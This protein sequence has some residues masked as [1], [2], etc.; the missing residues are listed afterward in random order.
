MTPSLSGEW[1]PWQWAQRELHFSVSTNSSRLTLNPST[2]FN[3][4][5]I[6]TVNGISQT[7]RL[8][9][10]C[11]SIDLHVSQIG[12]SK[13]RG[14]CRLMVYELKDKSRKVRM[15]TLGEL[16]NTVHRKDILRK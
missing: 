12:G 14:Q 11:G 4:E 10:H 13:E 6:A 9:I 2:P 16:Y 7:L 5:T 1:S 3:L 8:N 15:M